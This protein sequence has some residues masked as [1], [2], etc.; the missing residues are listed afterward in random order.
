MQQ[1]AIRTGYLDIVKRMVTETA[2]RQEIL[3]SLCPHFT[4]DKDEHRKNL[5]A[6][7]DTKS[8]IAAICNEMRTYEKNHKGIGV[9][10]LFKRDVPDVIRVAVAMLLAQ[11]HS[12]AVD[13]D[14]RSVSRL[15]QCAAGDDVAGLVT[16][17]EAF[18]SNGTL[19]PFVNF[20]YGRSVDELD[21]LGFKESAVCRLLNYT[22]AV[23]QEFD[24]LAK[25]RE[26]NWKIRR[27]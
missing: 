18:H 10:A 22:M 7:L 11:S 15:A 13:H 2:T 14:C 8:R 27:M 24:D 26:L 19:R 21:R 12:G 4:G 16:I 25:C 1:D 9:L 17:R 5:K 20:D 3:V 6:L 23:A